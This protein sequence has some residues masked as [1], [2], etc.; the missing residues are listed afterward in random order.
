MNV[1]PT[2]RLHEPGPEF[3]V[4]GRQQRSK[5]SKIELARRVRQFLHAQGVPELE[6]VEVQEI[7]LGVIALQGQLEFSRSKW[8][9]VNCARHV[10]GVNR[11]VD[12]LSVNGV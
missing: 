10:A 4:G 9:S 7:A 3:S 2:E 11:V 8:L 5:L 6:R 12:Q 1:T